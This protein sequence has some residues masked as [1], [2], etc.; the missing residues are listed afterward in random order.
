MPGPVLEDVAKSV[1]V[2]ASTV[3]RVL[4]GKSRGS[5]ALLERIVSAAEALGY[6]LERYRTINPPS[7]LIGVVLPN[8]SSLFYAALIAA[9]EKTATQHGFNV[10][11]SNSDYSLERERSCLKVLAE[12]KVDGLLLSP[13]ETHSSLPPDLQGIPVVQVDRRSESIQSDLVTTDSFQGAYDA[14]KL[15]IDQGYR[16]IAIISGPKTHSTGRE[17]LAGYASALR[18][19]NISLPAEYVQLANFRQEDGYRATLKL[20]ETELR[21]EAIF[22]SNVDM[23]IGALRAIHEQ[24]LHIPDDM[25]IIGFD[26]FTFA[27]ILV[28]PLTTVA[29]PIEMLGMTA[30]DLLVRRIVNS[31]HPDPVTIKLAPR[32]ILRQ[33][34]RSRSV[35]DS[36]AEAVEYEQET[37]S[38]TSR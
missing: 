20:L 23:T 36:A 34:T 8:I 10:L 37:P 14:V 26:D 3:S 9:V 33:S 30:V 19:A 13:V 15:L 6:S 35:N 27:S 16:R 12:K 4:R 31:A 28:P 11:L 5:P 29:Q 25:G 2:S 21:P 22:V 18:E 7:R 1:G 32:L 24:G 38:T 17:R